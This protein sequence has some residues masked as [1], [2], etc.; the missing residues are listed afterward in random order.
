LN[1]LAEHP[2]SCGVS[3]IYNEEAKLDNFIGDL[4]IIN[5]WV[6]NKVHS[7]AFYIRQYL[8][9]SEKD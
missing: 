9:T 7:K 2:V 3:R 1:T 6:L 8:V 5:Q 4:L